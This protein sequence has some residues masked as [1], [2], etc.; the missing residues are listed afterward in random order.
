[1]I[2]LTKA[3]MEDVWN[4]K[5]YGYWTHLRK[6][7]KGMKRFKVKIQPYK[8]DY[9]EVRELVVIAKNKESAFDEAKFQIYDEYKS[10]GLD[11][12]RLIKVEPV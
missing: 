9:Y 2:N 6:N 1:M 10:T 3:E 11:G 5:P 8:T 4:N 12:Y 7:N